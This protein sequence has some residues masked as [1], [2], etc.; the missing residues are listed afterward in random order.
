VPLHLDGRDEEVGMS[1]G[2]M[3]FR[4]TGDATLVQGVDGQ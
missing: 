2:W 1:S 3:V 4:D